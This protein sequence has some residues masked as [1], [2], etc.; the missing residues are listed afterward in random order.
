ERLLT[1]L[2]IH[3]CASGCLGERQYINRRHI[4]NM[5][6]GPSIQSAPDI[7]R[8]ASYFDLPHE[9]GNLDALC[10]RTHRTAAAHRIGE[11][12][13]PDTGTLKHQPVQRYTC[14]LFGQRLNRRCLIKDAVGWLAHGEIGDDAASARMNKGFAGTGHSGDQGLHG[15]AMVA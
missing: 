15:A 3:E 10:W 9:C 13:G 2:D 5:H 12:H 11:H 8:Y 6:V 7:T 1:T 4:S 14:G